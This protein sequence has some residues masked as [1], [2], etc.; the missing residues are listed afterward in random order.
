MRGVSTEDSVTV[1]SGVVTPIDL[2]STGNEKPAGS[3]SIQTITVH[4]D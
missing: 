1:K 4:A 3:S 2:T